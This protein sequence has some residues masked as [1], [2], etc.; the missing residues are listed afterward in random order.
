MAEFF[1][2]LFFNPLFEI[3]FPREAE[4]EPGGL[5]GSLGM[6]EDRADGTYKE[7]CL[8]SP[9]KVTR[10]RYGKRSTMSASYRIDRVWYKSARSKGMIADDGYCFEL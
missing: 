8:T 5:F 3:V 10:D 7:I 6:I 9:I 2:P 4:I 1:N